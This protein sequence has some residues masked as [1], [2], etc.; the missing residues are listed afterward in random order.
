MRPLETNERPSWAFSAKIIGKPC[1][2]KDA[3]R[4]RCMFIS[5]KDSARKDFTGLADIV[6]DF[7]EKTRTI[8]MSSANFVLKSLARF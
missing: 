6:V 4:L 7:G 2:D 3:D 5:R 8:L 1:R